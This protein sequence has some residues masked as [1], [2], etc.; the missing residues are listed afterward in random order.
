MEN[1]KVNLILS[2]RKKDFKI[3]WFSGTGAGGQYRNKHQNCCRITHIKSG[4]TESDT[5]NRS[6]VANFRAAFTRLANKVVRHELSKMESNIDINNQVIRNYNQHRNE[7]HDKA[8]GLKQPY[9]KVIDDISDMIEAR[10]L[11]MKQLEI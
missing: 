3:D 5:S 8:S 1:Q 6:R 7:V 11:A 9:T 4:M 10:Y 2:L